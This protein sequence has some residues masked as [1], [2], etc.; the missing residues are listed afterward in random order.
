MFSPSSIPCTAC[1]IVAR[2]DSWRHHGTRERCAGARQ[3]AQAHVS[4]SCA[5]RRRSNGKRHALQRRAGGTHLARSLRRVHDAHAGVGA[6]VRSQARLPVAY[7]RRRGR[8]LRAQH[9][10]ACSRVNARQPA[11]SSRPHTRYATHAHSTAHTNTDK[12]PGGALPPMR[13]RGLRAAAIRAL[14][15]MTSYG[16]PGCA[17]AWAVS[18]SRTPGAKS[19]KRDVAG[20]PPARVRSPAVRATGGGAPARAAV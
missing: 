11:R 6:P 15:S 3:K 2:L 5:Q 13:P 1:S 19:C 17:V 12:M 10:A 14:C 8:Q 16:C 20:W 7:V 18:A 9:T 4:D